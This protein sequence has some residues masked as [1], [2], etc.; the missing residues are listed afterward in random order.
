MSS[1]VTALSIERPDGNQLDLMQ[2]AYLRI[3]GT[4]GFRDVIS[5][6]V[7][8]PATGRD[9][10]IDATRFRDERL[11]TITGLVLDAVTN[12][13]AVVWATWGQVQAAFAGAVDTDRLLQWTAGGVALQAHVRLDELS[14][15]VEVGPNVLRWQAQLRCPS[16]LAFSQQLESVVVVGSDAV[17]GGGMTMPFAFPVHF[18]PVSSTTVAVTNQGSMP[19]P[20]TLILRGLMRNP[21]VRCGDR[22]I[23]LA[24]DIAPGDEM[25][26]DTGR[27]TVLLNNQPTANRRSMLRAAQSRWFSLP[28][29]VPTLLTLEVEDFDSGTEL[30]IQFRHAY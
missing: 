2:P 29:Q 8:R 25:W 28:P 3:T 22:R 6:R 15:P 14:A 10:A 19:A 16:G 21:A 11:M 24:G 23:V 26:I 12:D 5:R 4:Q 1:L 20:V 18:Q 7:S 27:R 17:G 30:E 13:P 9:G